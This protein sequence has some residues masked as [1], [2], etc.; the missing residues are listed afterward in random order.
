MPPPKKI[1]SE[2]KKIEFPGTAGAQQKAD[3]AVQ[4]KDA[5]DQEL[6][7]PSKKTASKTKKT[8]SPILPKAEDQ[9]QE[10]EELGDS[11]DGPKSTPGPKIRSKV[12]TVK[13]NLN[14][15]NSVEIPTAASASAAGG[16]P[17]AG[18]KTGFIFKKVMLAKTKSKGAKKSPL[19]IPGGIAAKAEFGFPGLVNYKNCHH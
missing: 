13:T 16:L 3:E 7:G 8:K 1:L 11:P 9:E 10:S 4:G 18:P 15:S 14:A 2:L 6:R 17:A 12:S 5:G 19:P